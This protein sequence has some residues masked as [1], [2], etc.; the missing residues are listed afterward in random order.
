M[1]TT[2]FSSDAQ[3]W[4]FADGEWT[5]EAYLALET[6]ERI[7]LLDG[8]LYVFPRPLLLHQRL[9][10]RLLLATS[11]PAEAQGFE[12][13]Q[14]INVRL[15]PRR[16]V[17]PDVVIVEPS[18]LNERVL[19]ASS[20]R[21]VCEITSPSNAQHDRV[22]KMRYYAE[23]GIDWYLL[24]EPQPELTLHLFRREGDHYVVSAEAKPGQTLR[25]TDPVAVE[26]EPA[27]M[28]PPQRSALSS[29]A[30]R[31]ATLGS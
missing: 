9:S 15:K 7:E 20:V 31:R 16:L 22:R 18:D 6:D 14:E 12:V 30:S 13:Y 10:G 21:L 19:E 28:L 5:E 17:V 2:A 26:L 11:E 23:A 29:V 4:A 1:T 24:V 27:K 25:L 3:F 8:S